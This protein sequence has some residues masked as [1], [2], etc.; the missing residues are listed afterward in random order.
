MSERSTLFCQ[1]GT[2][3]TYSV[4][5]HENV[6]YKETWSCKVSDPERLVQ[7]SNGRMRPA[8]N[9]H[10]VV[11]FYSKGCIFMK[12]H[13][14]NLRWHDFGDEPAYIRYWRGTDIVKCKR[15]YKNGKLHGDHDEPA[16]IEYSG[17]GIVTETRWYNNNVIE[18]EGCQPAYIRWNENG[19]VDEQWYYCQGLPIVH[20]V[21]PGYEEKYNPEDSSP[22]SSDDENNEEEKSEDE[23]QNHHKES[24]QTK[25]QRTN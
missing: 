10:Q 9:L 13:R 8:K 22:D 4:T 17:S 25:K 12:V 18:R 23:G 3:H 6:L 19:E 2:D 24:R 15:W 7:D 16:W 1:F 20:N 21:N 5:Y 14:L 11:L